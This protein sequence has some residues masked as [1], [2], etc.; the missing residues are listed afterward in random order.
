MEGAVVSPD[1]E[2]EDYSADSE[3]VL[4]VRPTLPAPLVTL[5]LSLL[6]C[7]VSVS[8]S[9]AYISMCSSLHMRLSVII[10]SAAARLVSLSSP[11]NQGVG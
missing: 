3:T 6:I 10:R 8:V 7:C 9:L 11:A 1:S 2:L 5:I 4:S